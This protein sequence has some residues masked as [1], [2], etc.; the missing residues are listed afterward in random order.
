MTLIKCNLLEAA[1]IVIHNVDIE[2]EFVVIFVLSRKTAFALIE[3]QRLR[4]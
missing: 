3:Q 1:A 2:S 4:L